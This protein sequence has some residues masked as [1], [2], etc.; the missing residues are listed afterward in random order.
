M[1]WFCIS[2]AIWAVVGFGCFLGTVDKIGDYIDKLK[3]KYL[4]LLL[5]PYGPAIWLIMWLGFTMDRLREPKVNIKLR[6]RLYKDELQE[7]LK[8]E[9]EEVYGEP[10]P[11]TVKQLTE[12]RKIK[13]S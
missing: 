1:L 11:E 5:F 12:T 6:M 7:D 8:K 10:P 9:Y 13:I 3:P 4:A 2:I